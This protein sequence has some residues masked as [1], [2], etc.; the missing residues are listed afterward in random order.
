MYAYASAS[1]EKPRKRFFYLSFC[2]FLNCASSFFLVD[3]IGLRDPLHQTCSGLEEHKWCGGTAQGFIDA[4]SP[5]LAH[6]AKIPL[7][8]DEGDETPLDLEFLCGRRFEDAL[9]CVAVGFGRFMVAASVL[10]LV[11]ESQQL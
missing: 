3:L 2:F 9:V 4:R 6:L 11:P 8:D 10:T 5:V 1:L 7:E